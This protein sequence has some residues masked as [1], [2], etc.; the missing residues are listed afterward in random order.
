MDF[1]IAIS[2]LATIDTAAN[3]RDDA[4][5]EK[6]VVAK[7]REAL[8]AQRQE[9][10]DKIEAYEVTM[11]GA[12]VEME[13]RVVNRYK[14]SPTFDY[15][16]HQTYYWMLKLPLLDMH[17]EAPLK[18]G[19]S[20]FFTAGKRG[21]LIMGDINLNIRNFD[22]TSFVSDDNDEEKEVSLTSDDEDLGEEE[23]STISAHLKKGKGVSSSRKEVG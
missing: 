19:K 12:G 2:F 15:F 9:L 1:S 20:T 13:T 22:Y 6:Y 5:H 16:I 7:E 17:T 18:D 10:L 11:K 8:Q 4:I 14:R 23:T 21:T 3:K